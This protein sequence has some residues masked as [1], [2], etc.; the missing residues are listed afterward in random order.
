MLEKRKQKLK[1]ELVSK[2]AVNELLL[3]R[4]CGLNDNVD[5]GEKIGSS[6]GGVF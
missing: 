6:G 4:G 1:K 2:L 3:I 5:H